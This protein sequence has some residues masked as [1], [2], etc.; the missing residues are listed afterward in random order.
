MKLKYINDIN[1]SNGNTIEIV[2]C[3]SKKEVI[4]AV[5]S[6]KTSLAIWSEKKLY[7]RC[8]SLLKIADDFIKKEDKIACLISD[9]MG[10]LYRASLGEVEAVAYSIKETVTLAKEAFSKKI[11]CEKNLRTELIYEPLGVVAVITPW[12]FPALMPEN[13]LTPALLA[14]NTVVFKPSE[15]APLTGKAVFEIYSKHLPKGVINILHGADEVGKEVVNS[16]IDM[17]AFVGSQK[18]GKYIMKAASEYLKRI[19]LELGGK[20]PMIV[21]DNADL[22]S[23][24]KYAVNGSLRNSGQVCVSVERI[25]VDKKIADKFIKLVLNE[26]QQF[27]YGDIYAGIYQMGPMVSENQRKHVLEQI[28]N[29][30]RNGAKLIYGGKADNRDGGF[31]LEP[32]VLTNLT[33][34]HKIMREETFG[35]VICIQTVKDKDEAI[36][37]ANDTTFGLGATVWGRNFKRSM[38]VAEKIKAGMMGINQGLTSVSNT[39]W[40]GIKQSGYAFIGS[41]DGMRNF[42]AVRKISYSV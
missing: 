29:A 11:L 19:V 23:A 18:V 31:Y 17:I 20:D 28:K 30:V 40:V 9:E 38:K 14:G 42:T 27:K 37:L 4:Q 15:Y 34:K 10:K 12:N 8:N 33:H 35:P 39:P 1:P 13:L 25:Y 6:A 36:K 24:A 2:K 26:V 16:D 5:N 7:R 22:K 3:S 41:V 32:A 21:L